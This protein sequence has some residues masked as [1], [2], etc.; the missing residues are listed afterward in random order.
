MSEKLIIASPAYNA[1]RT[2]EATYNRIPPEITERLAQFIIV[3]DGSTDDTAEAAMRLARR[4]PTVTLINHSENRGYSGACKTGLRA[5]A[6]R[7]ADLV[8]WL[9][10]D[11][12]YAPELIPDMLSPLENDEADVTQGSRMKSG[13][14]LKGGMPLYKFLA[15]R[16]LTLLKNFV[17]GMNL[18]EYHSGYMAYRGEVLREVPF[19]RFQEGQFIFDQEMMITANQMGYRVRDVPIFTRYADEESHLRPVRYG[20]NVLAMIGRYLRGHYWL[21]HLRDGM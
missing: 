12:Q 20:L 11:G 17:F 21:E 8:V 7:G 14:A 5:A 18:A 3:N 16:T 9:H 10:A 4:H 15:N 6:D 1:G 13:G 19:E 2:L